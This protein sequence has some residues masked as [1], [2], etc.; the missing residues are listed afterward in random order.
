[1]F[2]LSNE[3]FERQRQRGSRRERG[4]SSTWHRRGAAR[5]M[6]RRFGVNQGELESSEAGTLLPLLD[7]FIRRMVIVML[8]AGMADQIASRHMEAVVQ[9]AIADAE[10]MSDPVTAFLLTLLYT[11]LGLRDWPEELLSVYQQHRGDAMVA[12]GLRGVG[13]LSVPN[14]AG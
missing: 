2:S 7:E 5:E 3:L 6:L 14:D 8:A 13:F 1:M 11:R 10:L 4:S 9:E 12:E